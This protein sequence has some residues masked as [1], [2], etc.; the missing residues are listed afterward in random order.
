MVQEKE[1]EK[2]KV[3]DKYTV[4]YL[5]SVCDSVLNTRVHIF[6]GAVV[7]S[8]WKQDKEVTVNQMKKAIDKFL[9]HKIS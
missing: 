7:L 8:E 1:K 6:D 5:R 9:N 4:G 3:E 2:V